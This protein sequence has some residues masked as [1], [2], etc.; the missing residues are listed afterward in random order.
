MFQWL[1]TW[2]MFQWLP[3]KL[4]FLCL[5]PWLITRLMLFMPALGLPNSLM[6][7]ISVFQWL[8]SRLMLFMSTFQWLYIGLTWLC[9][10]FSG[11]I[12]LIWFM[13]VFQWLPT[14]LMCTLA[15]DLQLEQTPMFTSPSLDNKETQGNGI[16]DTP[17]LTKIN[18]RGV[19]YGF[20]YIKESFILGYFQMW[21]L[22]YI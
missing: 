2:L 18:L 11:S 17:R 8:P 1:L 9:Q 12:R 10:C 3:T 13:F 5:F 15:R 20:F 7:F 6:V 16:S 21:N 19:R 14:R 22:I 4:I